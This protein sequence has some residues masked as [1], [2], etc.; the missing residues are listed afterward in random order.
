MLV[1]DFRKDM[2]PVLRQFQ[3]LVNFLNFFSCVNSVNCF[4]DFIPVNFRA[5]P[6][7]MQSSKTS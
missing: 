3:N 7:S 5:S 1:L 6:R 4:S 2:C